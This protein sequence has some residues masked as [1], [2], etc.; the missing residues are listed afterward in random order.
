MDE[1][2]LNLYNIFYQ[3]Q[4]EKAI[5]YD[6]N[7]LTEDSKLVARVLQ[8]RAQIAL[9]NLDEVIDEVHQKIEPEFIALRALA[10]ILKRNE[11]EALSTVESLGA[12]K[13]IAL[14]LVATTLQI[15]GKSEEALSMLADHQGDCK[16]G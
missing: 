3:G 6:T 2:L 9:G 8:L 14:I 16:F 10:K 1:K 7:E 11:A 13:G 5:E 4:F 15:A 12:V